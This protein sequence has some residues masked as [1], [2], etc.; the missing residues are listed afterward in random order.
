MSGEASIAP[1]DFVERLLGSAGAVIAHR[2]DPEAR[3]VEVELGVVV[4]EEV[5]H[6]V[7]EDEA[8]VYA[9]GVVLVDEFAEVAGLDAFVARVAG[10]LFLLVVPCRPIPAPV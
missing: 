8:A 10:L 6:G 5:G 2:D 7:G 3:S 1:G 9:R 4:V